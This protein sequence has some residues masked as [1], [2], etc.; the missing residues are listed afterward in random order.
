MKQLR[1]E[2]ERL[3][4]VKFIKRPS[5][6]ILESK[7]LQNK[8][9]P[10]QLV[11]TKACQPTAA[12]TSRFDSLHEPCQACGVG[13]LLEVKGTA[14]WALLD[15]SL[16]LVVSPLEA[17]LNSLEGELLLRKVAKTLVHVIKPKYVDVR[18]LWNLHGRHGMTVA[19]Q[20]ALLK[21]KKSLR[22]WI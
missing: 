19:F 14:M 5:I 22:R 16:P 2:F 10:A 1:A 11:I 4:S 9:L 7:L 15:M 20:T 12:W 3:K 6:N 8:L 18:A 21:V 17:S 13:C